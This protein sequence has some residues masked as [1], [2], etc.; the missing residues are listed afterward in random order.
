M[1]I[2]ILLLNSRKIN[3]NLVE[4]LKELDSWD[5]DEIPDKAAR[6]L[7]DP[8]DNDPVPAR[9]HSTSGPENQIKSNGPLETIIKKFRPGQQN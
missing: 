5:L 6:F 9:I 4:E 7:A 2:I 8:E 3:T 1:C